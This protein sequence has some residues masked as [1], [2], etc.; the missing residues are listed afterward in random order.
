M[1]IGLLGGTFDPPHNGH[2]A[3]A[4]Y[5]LEKLGLD[6]IIFIPSRRTPL[7]SREDVSGRKH[8]WDM[9]RELIKGNK[10]YDISD[11][12]LYRPGPSYTIDTIRQLKTGK[13]KNDEFYFIT[14]WDSFNDLPRWKEAGNLIKLCKIVAFTRSSTARPDLKEMDKMVP[15][16]SESSIIIDVPPV[17]ISSTE[18]RNRVIKGLS[19]KDM[20]PGPVEK[21][22]LDN[23]LYLGS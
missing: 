6:K 16:L 1:K 21:Y 17:D 12:E 4:K 22:I 19:V 14:G 3:I 8:R 15:G 10:K 20:V 2:L 9:L 5:A 13:N 11:I 23:G 7:K 18:V